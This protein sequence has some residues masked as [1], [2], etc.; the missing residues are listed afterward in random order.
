MSSTM[1]PPNPAGVKAPATVNPM[2][3]SCSGSSILS[4]ENP[5][6]F[7]QAGGVEGL[8]PL[9][10]QLPHIGAATGTVVTDGSAGHVAG[11]PFTRGT[12]S[13]VTVRH[14]ASLP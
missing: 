4:A 2:V 7:A 10:N 8:E 6:R 14:A 5:A 12:R 13:T 11:A 1:Q 3:V 9:L